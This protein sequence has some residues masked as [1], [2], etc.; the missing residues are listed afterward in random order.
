[1]P[2]LVPPKPPG[3][4]NLTLLI[5]GETGAAGS[6]AVELRARGVAIP[7]YAIALAE[8]VFGSWVARPVRW[9]VKGRSPS[10]H[11]DMPPTCFSADLDPALLA[12]ASGVQVAVFMQEAK[13]FSVAFEWGVQ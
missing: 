10:C 9:A 2:L 1:M 5:N 3:G 12:G 11:L 6:I 4:Q 7:P 13:V 8:A